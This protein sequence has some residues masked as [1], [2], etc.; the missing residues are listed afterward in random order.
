MQKNIEFVLNQRNYFFSDY[1]AYGKLLSS[2]LNIS[3]QKQ[4]CQISSQYVKLSPKYL[5][6]K[7][8]L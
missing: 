6:K 2:S 8:K 4:I 3:P 7:K 1:K 5:K